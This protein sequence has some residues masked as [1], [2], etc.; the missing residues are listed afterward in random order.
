MLS[1]RPC[2]G[3]VVPRA[4]DESGQRKPPRWSPLWLTGAACCVALCVFA[5]VV[6]PGA[7]GH[8]S[9]GLS[10]ASASVIF[11]K[12]AGAAG[13][14]TAR[15]STVSASFFGIPAPPDGVPASEVG[16]A[17]Q[18]LSGPDI[19][20]TYHQGVMA[21]THCSS[22]PVQ[23]DP[24]NGVALHT[25]GQDGCTALSSPVTYGAGIFEARI[26]F[27]GGG[28]SS[29]ANWPAFYMVG[30]PWPSS[31]EIDAAEGMDG[32]LQVTYHF[33]V[34]ES[35]QQDGP[36]CVT[37]TPGW[38]VVTIVRAPGDSQTGPVDSVYYDGRKVWTGSG[39]VVSSPE[40]IVVSNNEG[41]H[42]RQPGDAADLWI[43]YIRVWNWRRARSRRRRCRD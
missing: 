9:Q 15:Q 5:V 10:A 19:L 21:G 14:T 17:V 2:Y 30:D 31:G 6:Y 35:P 20:R 26:W 4:A 3:D 33:G 25:D 8:H 28:K 22:P 37:S 16:A 38:H 27:A 36:Y 11:D 24:T 42:G 13:G 12:A 34:T 18:N 39:Y 1:T 41:P 32:C 29:I 43:N 7:S 40:Y 23:L